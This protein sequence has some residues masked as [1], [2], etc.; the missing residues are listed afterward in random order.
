MAAIQISVKKILVHFSIIQIISKYIG[1]DGLGRLLN[2][3]VYN[4]LVLLI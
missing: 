3:V 1:K 2:G 4:T